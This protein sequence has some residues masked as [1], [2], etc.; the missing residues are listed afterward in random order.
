LFKAYDI[1]GKYGSEV[2]PEKF[3]V[4]GAA[5][6]AEFA[7]EITI[8]T[9]YRAHN[10]E[11][12]EAFCSGFN[13]EKTILGYAPSPATAFLSKKLGF[14]ITA[15]HNPAEYAGGKFFRNRTYCSE[16]EMTALKRRF[17]TTKSGGNA[18]GNIYDSPELMEEYLVSLPEFEG[19]IYDL[20]GGAAC[21]IS[22]VFPATIF[23]KPDPFFNGRSPEPK[24]DTLEAL[25]RR[26][27]ARRMVGFAF[28][29]DADRMIPCDKGVVLEG[30]VAAA[31]IA[32]R[33]LKKG[34][35]IVLSIDCRQ[36]VFRRLA[37]A[38]FGVATSKVG[39]RHAHGDGSWRGVLGREV[40]PL[41]FPAPR[42]EFGRHLRSCHHFGD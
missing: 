14:S 42:A 23:S 6:S 1:R 4:L 16:G 28:D 2:T 12:L 19:G 15:S 39:E 10:A 25:R 40:G 21:A 37:D 35:G 22:K 29:G 27:I 41:R 7:K 8:G 36:E 9:D 13:G 18:R 32:E 33:T 38:G 11:L 24:A 17:E 30:D 26:T 34:D 20:G 31:F 5:A 3:R